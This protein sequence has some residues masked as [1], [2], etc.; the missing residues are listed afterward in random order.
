[1]SILATPDA[2][3][4]A[5]RARV[6]AERLV[7]LDEALAAV[8]DDP[9]AI[10]TRFSA[11]GRALGRGPLHGP[12][13]GGSAGD[14]HVWTVDD[15]ARTLLLL[16][17]GPRVGDELAGLYRHGDPAERRGILRALP[18][19]P[20]GDTGI[21]LVADALRG[22]DVGLV[23][24]ALGP[25]AFARLDDAA[26]AQAVLKCAFVGVPLDALEGLEAR[27]TP[28]L[29]RMLAAYALERVVAG[30]SVPVDV[31]PLVARYPAEG[32]LAAIHAELDHPD[33]ERRQAAR[34]ALD[35][36]E[37]VLGR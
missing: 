16:A 17:L 26:I 14:V 32:E 34:A 7:W 2:L 10:R 31:W 9:G 4:S 6:P 18:L 35:G 37:S 15:A 12:V 24:A 8:G 19:L 21:A 23:A 36:Y 1:V 28:A 20:V 22:N 33:A 11:V 3:R 25:Y 5:L 13:A 27:A 29:A 30:R